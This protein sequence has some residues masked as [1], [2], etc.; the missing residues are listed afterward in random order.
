VGV[1]VESV[2]RFQAFA[3]LNSGDYE[4]AVHPGGGVAGSPDFMRQ[5]YSSDPD[6]E[7]F[8]AAHGYRNEEFDELAERQRVTFDEEERRA[9]FARMQEI[10]ADDLPLLHLY[11]P[12]PFLV[13]RKGGFDA[14]TFPDPDT[15][16]NPETATSGKQPFVTG[17][18]SGLEIRP[19]E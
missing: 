14:W 2:E 4:M 17:R 7:L 1:E 18:T 13:Q 11:Y 15:L 6:T 12:S 9:V 5:I 3:R 19:T 10:V 16:Y 8:F